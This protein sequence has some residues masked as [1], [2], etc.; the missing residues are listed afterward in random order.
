MYQ[1]KS[2]KFLGIEAM[3]RLKNYIDVNTVRKISNQL[4]I[5]KTKDCQ[6]LLNIFKRFQ[7]TA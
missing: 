6:T 5:K 7:T 1:N 3:Y 4:V 2:F